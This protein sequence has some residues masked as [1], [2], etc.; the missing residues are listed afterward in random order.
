MQRRNSE[1]GVGSQSPPARSEARTAAL[2]SV[3]CRVAGSR[4]GSGF[5]CG[6]RGLR[7]VH[8]ILQFFARLEVRNFF[9]PHFDFR[10]RLRIAAHPSATISRTKAAE[11]PNLDFLALLQRLNNAFEDRL[12]DGLR[13]RALQLRNALHF[14]DRSEER[15]V[16]KECRSRWYSCP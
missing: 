10:A 8:K 6:G 11:S 9:R 15:R 7:A 3:L 13:F 1:S 2:A 4:S 16:G 14:S 12:H 5:S